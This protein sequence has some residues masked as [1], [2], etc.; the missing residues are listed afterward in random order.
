MENVAA[1]CEERRNRVDPERFVDFYA[2]KGWKIG[3]ESMKDWK[4]A[5]RTWEKRAQDATSDTFAAVLR[6]EYNRE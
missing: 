2:A 6:E 5:V 1:Y 4:A 3:K